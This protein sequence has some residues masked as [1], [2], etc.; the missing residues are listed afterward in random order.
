MKLLAD[1][2]QL[3]AKNAESHLVLLY[4]HQPM[5]FVIYIYLCYFSDMSKHF[6]HIS[7]ICRWSFEHLTVALKPKHIVS[8]R[9]LMMPCLSPTRTAVTGN[10]PQ[11]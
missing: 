1:F 11:A 9:L 6:D 8:K 7:E 4:F 10:T 3:N 5:Y 2:C